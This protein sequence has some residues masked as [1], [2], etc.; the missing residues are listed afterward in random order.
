MAVGERYLE[1][2]L[3]S[4]R[5]PDHSYSVAARD[6]QFWWHEGRYF[7]RNEIWRAVIDRRTGLIERDELVK[8][9]CALVTYVPTGV[10]VLDAGQATTRPRSTTRDGSRSTV[11]SASG[12][13]R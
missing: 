11:R 13:A 10:T 2:E 8:S 9:N 5:L 12:S 4:D 1:G 6:E 3:R 7:R